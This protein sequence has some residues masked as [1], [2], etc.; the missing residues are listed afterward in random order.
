MTDRLSTLRAALRQRRHHRAFRIPPPRW[1]PDQQRWLE[2]IAAEVKTVIPEPAPDPAVDDGALATAA[3]NLW[4]ALR[5]LDNTDGP[6]PTSARHAHHYL[7]TMRQT[8]ADAGLVIYDHDGEQFHP[9]LALEVL[10]RESDE[11]A[12]RES[13]AETVRPTLF[14]H[15]RRIQ[16][17]QVI[18]TGPPYSVSDQESSHA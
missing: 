16:L 8:L 15:D 12:D 11:S 10:V 2:S 13:V 17:G 1:T 9:G 7:R 4:R 6:L 14:L 18:V 5:K 3:T